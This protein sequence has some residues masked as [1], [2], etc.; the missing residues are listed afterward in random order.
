MSDETDVLTR[1]ISEKSKVVPL[2]GTFVSATAT[3]FTVDVGGGRIPAVPAT[4]YLPLVNEPVWVWFIDGTPYVVGPTVTKPDRG[5]VATVSGGMVRLVT[6]FGE[7]IAPYSANITPTS[8]QTMKLTWSGGAYAIS[9]MSNSPAAP[10]P[11]PAPG[12]GVTTH[13]DTFTALDGGSFNS[14]W[15]TSLFYASNTYLAA[16][17]FGTKIADTIPASASVS[18]VEVYISPQQI[19]GSNPNF[20]LH[21]HQSRPGGP[22]TLLSSTP[23]DIAAGWIGLPTSFGNALK[24][25]GG[26]FGI[27]LNHGGYNILRSL[28]QDG[29]SMAVRITSTY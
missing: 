3:T 21:A 15:S 10:T 22:P 19:Q 5:V 28:V 4:P 11:P 16:A 8:G 26:S 12:T 1:L 24:A 6:D 23:V 2:V 17:F 29:Q 7:V 20:A 9:V 13:V 18:A 27:G 14:S 25:G